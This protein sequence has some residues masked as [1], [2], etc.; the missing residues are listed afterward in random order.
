MRQHNHTLHSQCMH[1]VD[2]PC[3][4]AYVSAFIYVYQRDQGGYKFEF[5][6]VTK[7]LLDDGSTQDSLLT[8]H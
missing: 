1:A 3:L 4:C 5:G 8:V 7:P 2:L 6:L